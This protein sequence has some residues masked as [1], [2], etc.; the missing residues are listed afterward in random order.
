MERHTLTKDIGI[1]K[2]SKDISLANLKSSF[3]KNN[4]ETDSPIGMEKKKEKIY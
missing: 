1:F 4:P 2:R 3:G